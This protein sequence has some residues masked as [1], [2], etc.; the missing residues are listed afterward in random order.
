MLWKKGG[1]AFKL[2]AK[3][4]W[5]F[6]KGMVVTRENLLNAQKEFDTD[7]IW[8][9]CILLQSADLKKFNGA[10]TSAKR[11]YFLAST[12]AWQAQ[13]KHLLQQVIISLKKQT[14]EE[15]IEM[16]L[17]QPII[18]STRQWQ[19]HLPTSSSFPNSPTEEGAFWRPPHTPLS[20]ISFV[21]K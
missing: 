13:K 6:P 12:S 7:L 17:S 19:M 5:L 21:L 10:I 15:F 9:A 20:N 18:Y 3:F 14:L 1:D 16:R 11:A 2:R 8:A 4:L